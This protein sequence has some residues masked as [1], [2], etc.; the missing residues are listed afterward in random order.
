ML[1]DVQKNFLRSV[2]EPQVHF[3]LGQSAINAETTWKIYRNN[4]VKAHTTALADT[5]STVQ[6]IVGID[7]FEQLA[8]A[9]VA[10]NPSTSGDLNDYGRAFPSFLNGFLPSIPHGDTLAYLPDMARVDWA[11]FEVLR[12]ETL[13]S[14]T[15]QH[16]LLNLSPEQQAMVSAKPACRYLSS[17][18]P[19]Y[20]IW[21]LNEDEAD[22]TVNSQEAQN[23]LIA[24]T[25]EVKLM[26]MSSAEMAFAERWF[27]RHSLTDAVEAALT[28]DQQ[29]QLGTLL[30]RLAAIG[31]ISSLEIQ[32]S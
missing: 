31:A 28:I 25:H 12:M 4:Y 17:N 9:F 10:N 15:W 14:L 30:S 20:S 16:E 1:D 11:W 5:F 26:A 23:L 18:F 32:H 8:K 7:Y 29:F 13:A 6:K 27:N 22:L 21:R 3:S 24:R 19:I 2:M